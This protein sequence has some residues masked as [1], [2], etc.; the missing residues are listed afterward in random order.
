MTL[1]ELIEEIIDTGEDT[2]ADVSMRVRSYSGRGMSGREC[3]GVASSDVFEALQLI[4]WHAGSAGL[5]M[6][7]VWSETLG[8]GNVIYWPSIPWRE[9]IL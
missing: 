6:P 5:K 9:G 4:A 3:L 2:A 1:Q 7:P 8:K